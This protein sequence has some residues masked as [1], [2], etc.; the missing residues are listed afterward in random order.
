VVSIRLRVIFGDTDAMGVVYHGN[1]LRFFE[2]ARTEF[3]RATGHR[4]RDLE[5]EGFL[6]P[7]TEAQVRYIKPA[8]Y[9][10]LLRVEVSVAELRRASLRFAYRLL[11][12]EDGVLLAEGHTDHA[13]VG[14]DFRPRRFPEGLRA[15]L[16]AGP[17]ATTGG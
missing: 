5:D 9:D 16:E 2:A 15:V 4:Y 3:F 11:R 7:V 13:C 10:D 12:E 1:Y 14:R 8:R 17:S 6:L